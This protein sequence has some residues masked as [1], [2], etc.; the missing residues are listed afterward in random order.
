[1][2]RQ[3]SDIIRGDSV[4]TKDQQISME[5]SLLIT[6]FVCVL[7]GFFFI[8]CAF[9]L[10]SDRQKADDLTRAHCDAPSLLDSDASRAHGPETVGSENRALVHESSDESDDN[11]SVAN[12][13]TRALVVPVPVHN[14][15]EDPTFNGHDAQDV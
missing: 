12:E 11:E 15:T 2:S 6:T 10:V 4:S 13:D 8:M 14:L 1:M 3:I 5:Y 9:Y 7:G